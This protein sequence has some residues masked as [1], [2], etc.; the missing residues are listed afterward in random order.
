MPTASPWSPLV[1]ISESPPPFAGLQW[2]VGGGPPSWLYATNLGWCAASD[3]RRGRVRHMGSAP[4]VAVASRCHLGSVVGDTSQAHVPVI[5]ASPV[6]VGTSDP[7]CRQPGTPTRAVTK[8]TNT[9]A[10]ALG[11]NEET[12]S[13]PSREYFSRTARW[14][15]CAIAS[16]SLSL[17]PLGT[18]IP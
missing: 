15:I 8:S 3:L 4:N 11:D 2:F 17:S 7:S 12:L 5:L 1:A 16:A 9:S 18:R 13:R 10:L 6:S 14:S